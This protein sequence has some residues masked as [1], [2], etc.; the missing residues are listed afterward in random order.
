MYLDIEYRSNSTYLMLESALKFQKAFELLESVD[1]KYV[2]ELYAKKGLLAEVDWQHAK[3]FIHFLKVFDETTLKLFG[4]LYVTG[5]E[6]EKQIY[7]LGMMIST[8]CLSDDVDLKLM[9][10]RM[11]LKYDMY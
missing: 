3:Y 7:G 4:S 9:A 6:Y 11:K 10:M 5:N 2:K 1:I 8:W